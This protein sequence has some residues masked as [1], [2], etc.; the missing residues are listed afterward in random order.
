[1]A[2]EPEAGRKQRRV[3][4]LS[5][6]G[7]DSTLEQVSA[8]PPLPPSLAHA[9]VRRRP[10]APPSVPHPPRAQGVP[11]PLSPLRTCLDALA[12]RLG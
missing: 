6:A 3:T 7:A 10:P 9:L 5:V 8:S 2:E 11:V 12:F 1:M 4:V